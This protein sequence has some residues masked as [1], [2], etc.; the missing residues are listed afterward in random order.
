MQM[1]RSLVSRT[2]VVSSASAAVSNCG[3]PVMPAAPAAE[4][5]FSNRRRVNVTGIRNLSRFMCS[6]LQL[7]FEFVEKM[8][9]GAVGNDLLRAGLDEASFVQAQSI[10]SDSILGI[11][12]EPCAVENTAQRI[13]VVIVPG[14]E[15]SID[16]ALRDPLRLA[17]A[18]ICPF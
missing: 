17:G 15:A 1:L 3:A 11:V 6:N 9:V 12:F 18:E 7:V 14:R 4:S 8:P 16:H 10:I 13:E 2:L 5:A